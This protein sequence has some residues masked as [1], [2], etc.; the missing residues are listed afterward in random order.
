MKLLHWASTFPALQNKAYRF[1]FIGQTISI[2]G[3]W[4]QSVTLGWMVWELTHSPVKVGLVASMMTLPNL[5]IPLPAG[6][7]ADNFAKRNLLLI[8]QTTAMILAFLFSY[9]TFVHQISFIHI[10]ILTLLLGSINSLDATIRQAFVIEMVPKEHLSSAI[11]LNSGLFNMAR[12][13]G[14][15]LGGFIIHWF[16]PGFSFL[17]NALSFLAMIAA[18]IYMKPYLLIYQTNKQRVDLES[19]KEGFLYSWKHPIIRSLLLTAALVSI[20]G[21]SFLSMMPVVAEQKFGLKADGLGVLYSACGVGAFIAAMAQNFIGNNTNPYKIT[22]IG[23]LIF[24]IS[25]L[26]FSYIHIYTIDLILLMMAGFGLLLQTST[27]NITI[28]KIVPQD[29]RGRVMSWYVLLFLGL[30]PFGTYWMGFLSEWVGTDGAFLFSSLFIGI[31]GT[32]I[33]FTYQSK[34]HSYLTIPLKNK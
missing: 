2:S 30:N 1:Y 33:Y 9:F 22:F 34:I 16:G 6:A 32:L 14:P 18:L 26:L 13:I 29:L 15:S 19:I 11:S 31:I 24:A 20:G 28:Q 25:M 23:S 17:L 10:I 21:W 27:V 8:T 12:I 3:T 5:L 7:I 4:M